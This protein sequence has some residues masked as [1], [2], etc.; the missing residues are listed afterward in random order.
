MHLEAVLPTALSKFQSIIVAT[1]V[2]PFREACWHR[3]KTSD[4][5]W[6]PFFACKAVGDVLNA[7]MLQ[8]PDKTMLVLCGHT[9]SPGEASILPN[10]TVYTG[11]AEYQKPI[12]QR[13]LLVK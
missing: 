12:I 4:D 7:A 10:L 2:P 1:H 6:L 11:A 3:G 13:V 8:H 5:D 9:H